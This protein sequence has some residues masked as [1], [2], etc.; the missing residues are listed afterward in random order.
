MS[1]IYPQSLF[2]SS[3]KDVLK[4]MR[5]RLR[6]ALKNSPALE[7]QT[8]GEERNISVDIF[9]IHYKDNILSL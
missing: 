2:I 3:E 5:T 4:L 1:V 7:F 9:L 6:R 8:A